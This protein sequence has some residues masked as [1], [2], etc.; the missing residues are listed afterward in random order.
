MKVAIYLQT[1]SNP[2]K[3]K[4]L[5]R[6]GKGI[7]R[8]GKDRVIYVRDNK[9]VTADMAVI[10]GFYG[11]FTPAKNDVTH[12]FRKKVYQHQIRKNKNILFIDRDFFC[13]IG[14]KVNNQLDPHHFFR[15]SMG[16]IYF[17]EG[18]H[19]NHIKTPGRWETIK[20]A[21]KIGKIPAQRSTDNILV[22]LNNGEFGKSWA[23]KNVEMMPWAVETAEEIRQHSDKNI[24]IRFHPKIKPYLQDSLPIEMFDHLDN[25]YFSGGIRNKDPR[26]LLDRTM[27]DDILDAHASIFY[28]SSAS[29]LPALYNRPIITSQP[30]CPA[31]DV[32]NHS[33]ADIDNLKVF[34]K[35]EW[36]DNLANCLWSSQEMRKGTPWIKIRKCLTPTG[37]ISK[38]AFRSDLAEY[39]K[40]LKYYYSKF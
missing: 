17:D 20:A 32:A 34:P 25:I 5:E 13:D 4:I 28:T 22:S 26:V 39:N 11:N 23:T 40:Y 21:K 36:L 16:S 38:A 9:L 29:I 24:V 31:F 18:V 19:F 33:I 27:T 8:V 14:K 3:H 2:L 12:N 15:V 7:E 37:D 10:L 1:A 6:F 30:G 35:E